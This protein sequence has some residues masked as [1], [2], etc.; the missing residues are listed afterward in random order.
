MNIYQMA[1]QVVEEKKQ[2]YGGETVTIWQGKTKKVF[3]YRSQHGDLR[4]AIN[5]NGK[6]K[7]HLMIGFPTSFELTEKRYEQWVEWTKTGKIEAMG[8]KII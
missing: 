6:I 7:Y 3:V 4:M 1:K 5:D 2:W 8:Y